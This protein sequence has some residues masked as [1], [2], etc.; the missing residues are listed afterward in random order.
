ME[1]KEI[2]ILSE[3]QCKKLFGS[4]IIAKII[5]HTKDPNSWL[6]IVSSLSKKQKQALSRMLK[7]EIAKQIKP[8]KPKPSKPRV[9][10][11]GFSSETFK[12]FNH[13]R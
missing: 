12:R 7:K 6:E 4:T 5:V 10:Q 2:F 13:N 1:E 11:E 9:I 8:I 3:E